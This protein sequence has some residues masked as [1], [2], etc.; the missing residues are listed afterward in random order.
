M[1]RLTRRR[2]LALA[3][4]AAAALTAHAYA[5]P[6]AHG[7]GK[8]SIEPPDITGPASLKAHAASSGLL[9]GC[10]V[11]PGLL[12]PASPRYDPAYTALIREQASILVAENVMKWGPLRPTPTTYNFDPADALVAFAERNR[13]KIRGHNLCWHRQ[14][15]TWF[16]SVA[17]PANARALLVAHIET[18]AG[19]YAGRMHSWDVVNEAI[20]PKDGR[21][22]G[23]RISPWLKLAGP[24]YI[25]LA[26]HTA[27]RA[28]PQALLTYND[29]GIENETPEAAAK[30][31]AVLLLL[32]RLRA[33]RVP[34]D[35]V[36]IQS[37]IAAAPSPT[38]S[39]PKFTYGPGLL[40]FLADLRELDLQVFLT[41]MDV[42]DRALPPALPDRDRAVAETY[43]RYLSA[44]LTDPAVKAVLTW[45]ITDRYT[46]LNGEDARA[47][48]LPERPLPFDS[49]A[50]RDSA[51][52]HSPADPIPYRAK[53]AFFSL[54]ESLDPLTPSNPK[55]PSL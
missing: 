34:I 3:T 36:G 48:K 29:Y 2:L 46:W 51:D 55:R 30:R 11:A 4:Q 9:F 31:A 40:R 1:S 42:N 8:S 38:S 14:L 26:F 19:R 24:D 17:T 7:H 5:S 27:R 52:S 43:Q 15:P 6:F 23:L 10:A 49:G 21:P 16:A 44:V 13:M 39:D 45:G 12:D 54:R 20:E 22:D 53:P 32:R 37:H 33:R 50:S 25:E 35:A 28:D 41:E 18:V 47:D